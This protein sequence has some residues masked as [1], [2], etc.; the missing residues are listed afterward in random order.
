MSLPNNVHVQITTNASGDNPRAES[1]VRQIA[2]GNERFQEE[3]EGRDS[4]LE[5]IIKLARELI[6]RV[7]SLTVRNVN[8]CRVYI[9][10]DAE[11]YMRQGHFIQGSGRLITVQGR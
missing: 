11:S 1:F 8:E 5:E 4:E 9:D 10:H 3:I 6:E 7:G 2:H